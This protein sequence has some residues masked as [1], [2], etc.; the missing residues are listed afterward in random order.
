MGEKCEFHIDSVSYLGCTVEK[1][2]IR[3]DPVKIKAAIDWPTPAT[4]KNLMRFLGLTNFYHRFIHNFRKI[5][6]Q[7][8]NLTS[9]KVAFQWSN[10][11]EKAFSTFKDLFTSSPILIQP[12]TTQQFIVEVYASNSAVWRHLIPVQRR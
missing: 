10:A 2:S 7:F 3:A 9:P 6:L 1:G 5:A 11:A 8:T 12:D 4:R